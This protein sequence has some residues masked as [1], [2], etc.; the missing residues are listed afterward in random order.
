MAAN[1]LTTV[2]ASDVSEAAQA[3]TMLAGLVDRQYEK[4]LRFG[5][6]VVI[7]DRS[8]PAVRIK[9]E[10]TSATYSNITET[11][12]TLT[13]SRQAYCAFLVN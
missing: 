12:Q 5:R 13:I 2:W 1:F 10:D 4:D 8:N 6:T 7:R 3:N 9:T 11:Q